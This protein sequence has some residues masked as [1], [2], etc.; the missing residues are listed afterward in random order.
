MSDPIAYL[1][2]L[3]NPAADSLEPR[4]SPQ[5][6]DE[7]IANG[8][9]LTLYVPVWAQTPPDAPALVL[10]AFDPGTLAADGGGDVGWWHA[11]MRS[12]LELAQIRYQDQVDA[13]RN[14]GV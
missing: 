4:I 6:Y 3:A 10:T 5:R 11:Y 14:G 2:D 8:M 9:S 7:L 1:L 13:A 12:T